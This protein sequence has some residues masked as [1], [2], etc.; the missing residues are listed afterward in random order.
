MQRISSAQQQGMMAAPAKNKKSTPKFVRAL[1]D[2]VY[3]FNQGKGG[4]VTPAYAEITPLLGEFDEGND[5]M[6]PAMEDWL[7]GYAAEMEWYANDCLVDEEPQDEGGAAAT[8]TRKNIAYMCKATWGQ[9]SPYNDLIVFDG[10]KCATGCWATA[11]AI[12]MQYWGTKGYHRGCTPTIKYHYSDGW[13]NNEPLPS[14]TVFDY[15]NFTPS[16]P[17]SAAEIK[18]VAT[19]MKYVGYACK[20]KYSKDL[21]VV[22]GSVATPYLKT[23]LRLGSTISH[24]SSAKLGDEKFEKAIYNEI[25]NGRPCILNGFNSQGTGGHFFVADGYRVFDDK[26]HINWGWGSYNGYFALNA[27]KPNQSREYSYNKWATIGIQPDYV[28]GDVNQDGRVNITDV[29]VLLQKI[30][31]GDTTIIGD[32]NSDGKVNMADMMLIVNTILGKQML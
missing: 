21:T 22:S 28:L 31:D 10:E 7:T 14:I 1:N 30:Q 19:L 29:M 25:I 20:L 26:Y 13:T 3:L 2:N 23:A 5:D 11:V 16:K 6:P 8:E 17:K 24:I 27:L 18:A 15:R 4:I 9:G 32:I 12:I